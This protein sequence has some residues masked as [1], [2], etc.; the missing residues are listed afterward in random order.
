MTLTTITALMIS[1]DQR[2]ATTEEHVDIM[3]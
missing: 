3:E 1:S 2:G